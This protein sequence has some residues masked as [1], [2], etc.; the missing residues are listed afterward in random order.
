MPALPHGVCRRANRRGG[1]RPPSQGQRAVHEWRRSPAAAPARDPLEPLPLR[2]PDSERAPRV[3]DLPRPAR[4]VHGAVRCGDALPPHR[5]DWI[6]LPRGRSPHRSRSPPEKPQAWR[7]GQHGG[8]RVQGSRSLGSQ[9]TLRG[10]CAATRRVLPVDARADGVAEGPPRER[11][12]HDVPRV[13]LESGV[14]RARAAARPPPHARAAPPRD[15]GE[16]REPSRAAADSEHGRVSSAARR[17]RA[18][19]RV[20]RHASGV[21]RQPT[22]PEL[23]GELGGLHHHASVAHARARVAARAWSHPLARSPSHPARVARQGARI[24]QRV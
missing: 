18:V 16:T 7:S 4:V 23:G 3:P 21:E 15:P 11:R 13:H 12:G 2:Q 19:W 9:E 5:G 6:R 10:V 14:P 17:V 20:L 8:T 22:E 1:P 24:R